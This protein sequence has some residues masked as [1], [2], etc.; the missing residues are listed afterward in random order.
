MDIFGIP[1]EIKPS[2]NRVSMTPAGVEQCTKIGR[3]VL[4]EVDAGDGSEF[5]NGSYRR[6]GAEI[7]ASAEE[8]W[9]RS[10][11]IL[12]VKEP[13]RSEC[14]LLRKDQ[15]LFTYLH[16]SADREL[17]EA[18]CASGCVGIAYETVRK[19]DGSSPLLTPMSE[20]AGRM[21]AQ[22][23]AKYLEK[24]QGGRGI[25]LGGTSEVGPGTVVVLGGGIV[26]MNAAK[27]ACGL[28]ARVI[29]LDTNPD[30][31]QQLSYLMPSN[32]SMAVSTPDAIRRYVAEADAVIGAVLIPGGKA[33]KLVTC[34]MLKTMQRGAILV[35][36]AIDQG[37]CCETSRP[38]T[39]E[40]P[41]YEVDGILHY[42]VT[43]MPGAVPVTATK[44]LTKATLPY[45][46]AIAEKGWRRAVQ[47]DPELRLGLNV[48]QG[49]VVHPKVA[50]AFGMDCADIDALL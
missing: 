11:V 3:K 35:D 22:Q 34:D 18:M 7:V 12:K 23:A 46:L 15:V 31:L 41:V 50:E 40:D 6:A 36:V 38:T 16:L 33:P 25:L 24:P 13:Q 5:D 17:T 29:I 30:R 20:V 39:H 27:M 10:D 43:N 8:I 28:G 4:V 2:E 49:K 48:L 37:G 47:E 26:G 42:C 44:A 9:A 19:A 21:A 1:K 32:C 14:R 45:V